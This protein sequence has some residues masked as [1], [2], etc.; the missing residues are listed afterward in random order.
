VSVQK[1]GETKKGGGAARISV[2][3]VVPD[4][5]PQSHSSNNRCA[6]RRGAAGASES[7][8]G[9]ASV[10]RTM[11]AHADVETEAWPVQQGRRRSGGR[12]ERGGDAADGK[13]RGRERLGVVRRW[14]SRDDDGEKVGRGKV[15]QACLVR[16]LAPVARVPT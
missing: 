9:V 6:C 11:V 5:G 4:G 14:S 1:G 15:W 12:S 16:V 3:V 8:G 7:I 10:V 13:G 2:D